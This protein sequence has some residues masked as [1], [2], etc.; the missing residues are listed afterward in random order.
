VVAQIAFTQPVLLGMG[1]LFLE[2]QADLARQTTFTGADHIV[3]VRF[4]TNPRYGALDQERERSIARVR[5]RLAALPGVRGVVP[6]DNERDDARVSLEIAGQDTPAP[7]ELNDR[8]RVVSAAEGFFD[9][10]GLPIEAGRLFSTGEQ[11]ANR[12]I[13]IDAGLADRLLPGASPLGRRLVLEGGGSP[14]SNGVFTVIGV[15]AEQGSPQVFL[16]GTGSVTELLL[17]R[18]VGPADAALPAI[19]AAALAAAPEAPVVSARTLAAIHA[20]TRRSTMR[21]ALFAGGSGLVALALAAIGIYA[22]VAAAVE[23]RR[24]EIGIRAALGA[25]SSRTVG[26]FIRRGLALCLAGV[27]IGVPLSIGATRV[28]AAADGT[29]PPG[30]GALAAMVTVFVSSVALLAAWIPARRAASVDPL[31]VLRSE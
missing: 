28:A 29:Q 11:S 4:N 2:L 25:R 30:L 12:T 1:A 21:S 16:P 10:M 20:D 3:E 7:E 18:T 6:Q 5:D 8:I 27:A 14:R 22:V 17:V 24:R 9:V 26:L 13:V 31:T 15:V 19:R 23:Q